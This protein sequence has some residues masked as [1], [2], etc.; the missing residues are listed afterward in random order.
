MT[1]DSGPTQFNVSAGGGDPLDR[2]LAQ[3]REAAAGVYDI[4]GEMGR[5]KSGNVVYLAREIE[6]TLLV[7]LKL[8]RNPS[9]A[10]GDDYTLEV[11]R[12]LDGSL[13]GVESRCPECKAVLSDWERFCY[14]CG[15]DL[16]GGVQAPSAEDKAGLL[17]AVKE[18]TSGSYEILGQMD[19]A[20]GGGTVFFAKDLARD[21]KLVALR[22]RREESTDGSQAGYSI[23][24]TQVMRPLAAE[25]GKTQVLG[26]APPPMPPPVASAPAPAP[27]PA[28]A[29]PSAPRPAGVRSLPRFQLS[30]KAMFGIGGGALLVLI[31][32]LVF[33]GGEEPIQAPAPPAAD[34]TMP[35]VVTPPPDTLGGLTDT[36]LVEPP[37]PV[38]PPPASSSPRG[39]VALGLALPAG[40]EFRIDGSPVRGRSTEVEA[41]THHLSL[42]IRGFEPMTSTVTVRAGQTFSW[43]PTLRQVVAEQAPP[44]P[45]PAPPP[46]P[47][48]PSCARAF[49]R[50]DWQ[51]AADL[52]L[53]AAT[54][55]DVDAMVRIGRMRE[56]GNGVPRD[57]QQAA[58]WYLK[59]AEA[60]NRESQT[61][62]GYLYR[63]G[64][65]IKKD[66]RESARWF[67]AAADQGDPVA[68]VEYGEALENGD[69]VKRDEEAAVALYRQAAAA[70]S[71]G[72]ALSHLGRAY[73]RGKGVQKNE[74]EAARYYLQ[75]AERNDADAMYYLGKM[76]KDG[77]GVEKSPAQALDW[78]KRSAA[79][80]NRDAADEAR[81]LEKN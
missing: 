64:N 78:F 48:P 31:L 41:G 23:G 52:C 7:V 62:I 14:R 59:A 76:Y 73:E 20:E 39:T 6:T 55:G 66:E 77:R 15:A 1:G 29:K 68:M 36:A 33:R 18:A 72:A 46:P 13:P 44:K 5:S 35:V 61:R 58:N 45:A 81:K 69:G 79:L 70:G 65:G 71:G 32:V 17:E 12:T 42:S 10:G 74:A 75:A 2:L 37:A 40:A 43:R 53:E 21:G 8:Q 51:Q 16:S 27:P 22:L 60:G 9:G 3:V 80:G 26:A 67:K 25:L 4:L 50:S 47:P 34:T 11:V 56:L 30:R 38:P 57:M 19:R 49:G 28:P 54:K 24:E 63:S